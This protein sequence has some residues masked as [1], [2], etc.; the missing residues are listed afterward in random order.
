VPDDAEPGPRNEVDA[1]GE[2]APPRPRLASAGIEPYRPP[3]PPVAEVG[4]EAVQQA[5]RQVTRAWRH[6]AA[7]AAERFQKLGAA[8]VAERLRQQDPELLGRLAEI[9]VVRQAW[10]DDP[11]DGPPVQAARPLDVLQRAIEARAERAP[12]PL[13]RLGLSAVRVLSDLGLGDVVDPAA[14]ATLCFTDL[15]GFTEYTALEGDERARAL[16]DDYYRQ[17]GRI[18]RSRNG[19][20]VKHL[21]DG[22]LL[23]FAD[24]VDAVRAALDIVAAAPQPLRTRAGLHTG[25][26]LVERG[27]VF[28]HTVNV[29]ARVADVAEGGQVMISADVYDAVSEAAGLEFGRLR[30]HRFK[31]V[32]ERMA[33]CEVQRP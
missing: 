8:R 18:V 26:L 21:G 7:V 31:G 27:D 12:A 15:E 22:L 20:T 28:G 6:G 3:D 10:I 13:T 1:A 2:P 25:P 32:A 9:G 30:R 24:P 4:R 11:D 19:T 5:Q 29:A 33:I 14:E 23:R 17:S 16:L